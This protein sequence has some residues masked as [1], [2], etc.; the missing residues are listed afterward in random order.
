[1]KEDV[2]CRRC[3]LSQNPGFPLAPK[4]QIIDLLGW[5][6]IGEQPGSLASRG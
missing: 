6:S 1:M 2:A 3:E 5:R 4:D